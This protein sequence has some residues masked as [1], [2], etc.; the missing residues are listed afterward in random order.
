M[1]PQPH[2]LSRSGHS[3]HDTTL[4]T[5]WRPCRCPCPDGTENGRIWLPEKLLGPAE[6]PTATEGTVAKLALNWLGQLQQLEQCGRR[7]LTHS[8]SVA[9]VLS[10]RRL[11]LQDWTGLGRLAVD[12]ASTDGWAILSVLRVCVCVCGP[13]GYFVVP[14]TSQK[15]GVS[16]SSSCD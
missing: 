2:T 5:S 15:P 4:R 3:S 1:P 10:T 6:K 11:G 7:P 16:G 14:T 9:S 12:T 8:L 13:Q